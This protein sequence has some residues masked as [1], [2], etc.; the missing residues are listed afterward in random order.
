MCKQSIYQL[1][2]YDPEKFVLFKLNKSDTTTT[3]TTTTT[4]IST[5]TTTTT[6][7]YGVFAMRV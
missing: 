1:L 4:T 5:T 3:T 7:G 6:T 2:K